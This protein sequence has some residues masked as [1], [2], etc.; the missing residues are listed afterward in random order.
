MGLLT[1]LSRNRAQRP[2]DFET[3]RQQRRKGIPAQ[4][5][6]G[7][8]CLWNG[9]IAISDGYGLAATSLTLA[10]FLTTAATAFAAGFA[11]QKSG[12]AE[13]TSWET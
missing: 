11:V 8:P 5:G 1:S 13:A 6:S 10:P 12:S 3:D 4:L 2:P 9:H 7:C